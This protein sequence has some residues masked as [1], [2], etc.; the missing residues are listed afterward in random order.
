MTKF[1]CKKFAA[2]VVALF[3][4]IFLSVFATVAQTTEETVQQPVG[5]ES[6]SPVEADISQDP[7]HDHN[8]QHDVV[9][10]TAPSHDD[11]QA[12]E[13]AGHHGD[14]H[15]STGMPQLDPTTYPSQ[16]FWLIVTFFVLYFF[17]SKTILPAIAGVKD[18]R[19][20][21]IEDDLRNAKSMKE[22]ADDVMHSYKEEL[23]KAH[24]KAREYSYL[25][26]QALENEVQ[27]Q[28][29]DSTQKL[30][31][32]LEKASQEIASS[33]SQAMDEVN[34]IAHDLCDEI[35]EKFLKKKVTSDLI[36]KELKKVA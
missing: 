28:L 16:I 5:T 13:A 6:N 4:V 24:S 30:N 34:K 35:L 14:E 23:E 3:A 18:E 9:P 25:E 7:H 31:A 8:H 29:D 10:E 27:T 19:E 33:K 20:I 26:A 11:G 2:F 21:R 17:V 15:G 36:E 32:R 12:H 22:E 1:V